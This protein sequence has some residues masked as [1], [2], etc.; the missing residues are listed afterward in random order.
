M[1]MIMHGDGSSNIHYGNSLDKENNT[2]L[3]VKPRI[4]LTNPPFGLT[5]GNKDKQTKTV[6]DEEM[7]ILNQYAITKRTW[8]DKDNKFKTSSTRPSDSQILFIE[9]CLDLLVEGGYLCTVVDD[10]LLSNIDPYNRAVRETIL[11]KAIIRAVISL[12]DKTFKSKESGVK[13]SILLLKKK[14]S[15]T[16]Q[17]KVFMTHVEH[18]GIDASGNIDK[19]LLEERIIPSYKKWRQQI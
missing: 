8:D 3:N 9:R 13:P 12:P 4:I 11:E 5:I 17:G 7:K 16:V 10:G 6:P 2:W 14:L 18:V 15:G 19:D 1:N